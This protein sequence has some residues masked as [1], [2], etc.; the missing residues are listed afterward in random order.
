ME[1]IDVGQVW[2]CNDH[3]IVIFDA[4]DTPWGDRLATV[5]QLGDTK[6]TMYNLTETEIHRKY[7]LVTDPMDGG[8]R[9]NSCNYVNEYVQDLDYTCYKC[10]KGY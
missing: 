1:S 3:R 10:K 7:R 2:E 4:V 5:R 6:N 9:C 8:S